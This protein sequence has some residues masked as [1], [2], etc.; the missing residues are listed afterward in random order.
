MSDI[1]S[2]VAGE[3]VE[4]NEPLPDELEVLSDDPYDKGWIAKSQDRPTTPASPV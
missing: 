3:V 2:P 1:Y 4:V